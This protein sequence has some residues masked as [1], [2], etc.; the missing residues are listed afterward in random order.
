[1]V[2]R[3]ANV[4]RSNGTVTVACKLP[5]GVFL[6]LFDMVDGR[7]MT[8]QGSRT[9]KVARKRGEAIKLNGTALKFGQ[10]PDF[11][12]AHGYALTQVPADY[13]E[14]WCSQNSD[15]DLLANRIIFAHE[16]VNGVSGMAK[17]AKTTKI[18]SGMEPIDP[19]APPSVGG[20]LKVTPAPMT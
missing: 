10:I 9:T 18:K 14:E 8:P 3:V 6:Q 15:S 13:W 4:A 16:C 19:K 12:M 2:E 17:E 11:T 1:M 5:N 20:G 7:E